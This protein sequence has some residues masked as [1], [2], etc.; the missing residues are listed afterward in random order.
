MTNK[1]TNK[2]QQQKAKEGPGCHCRE[3]VC[4]SLLT[5]LC[6]TLCHPMDCSKQGFPVYH[7]LPEF[8]QT[9]VH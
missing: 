3:C 7:Q 1:Q 8:A 6:L 4:R 9:H 2:N 5:K